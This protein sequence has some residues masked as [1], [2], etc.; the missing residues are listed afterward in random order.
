[1]AEVVS[2]DPR[3]LPSDYENAARLLEVLG[4]EVAM[5]FSFMAG[6]YRELG[7][8]LGVGVSIAWRIV[9]DPD[10]NPGRTTCAR[11]LRWLST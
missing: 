5:K 10:F 8:E 11:V 4:E 3:R 2:D 6:G 9:N 1:M 7:D